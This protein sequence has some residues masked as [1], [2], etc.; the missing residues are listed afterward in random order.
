MQIDNEWMAYYSFNKDI[1]V[2]ETLQHVVLATSHVAQ[3]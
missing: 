3:A 2:I 1:G